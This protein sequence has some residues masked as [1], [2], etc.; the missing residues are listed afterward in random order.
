MLTLTEIISVCTINCIKGVKGEDTS[1]GGSVPY[2]LPNIQ[3]DVL[4]VNINY[5]LSGSP[6]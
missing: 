1:T 3:G 4:Y 5:Y 2:N 6:Y